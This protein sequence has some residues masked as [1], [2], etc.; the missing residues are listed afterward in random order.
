MRRREEARKVFSD[1]SHYIASALSSMLFSVYL[2]YDYFSD[3][4]LIIR[5]REVPDLLALGVISVFSILAIAL[6]L[7]VWREIAGAERSV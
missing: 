5:G 3:G 4:I 1:R 6:A 2:I 7:G